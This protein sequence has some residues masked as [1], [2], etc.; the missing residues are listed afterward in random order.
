MNV[1]SDFLRV[2]GHLNKKSPLKNLSFFK[3]FELYHF[4]NHRLKRLTLIS[5]RATKNKCGYWLRVRRVQLRTASQ[6]RDSA[7][8]T[9]ESPRAS[10]L[11]QKGKV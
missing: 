3:I 2:A 5:L 6:Y 11:N 7:V 10:K 8:C 9:P 1:S 4:Q